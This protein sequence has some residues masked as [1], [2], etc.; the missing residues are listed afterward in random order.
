M[1][2]TG[3]VEG[4]GTMDPVA[5]G[6]GGAVD[7]VV[8]VDATDGEENGAAG[9][10]VPAPA[11]A[12]ADTSLLALVDRLT[13]VL[14]R[15]DLGELEVAAGGTTIVLRAPS[16]VE[17]L[18]PVAVAAPAAAEPAAR[19]PTA[20]RARPGPPRASRPRRPRSRR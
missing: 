8:E 7:D 18:A 17:R 9:S 16:A 20:S 10:P 2:E 5:V 11:L 6:P 13:A 3:L 1:T 4:R 15:S 19:R 12:A 14:E